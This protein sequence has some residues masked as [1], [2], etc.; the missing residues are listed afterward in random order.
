MFTF[1]SQ[2]L[3]AVKGVWEG[4]GCL[5]LGGPMHACMHTPGFSPG[6][7]GHPECSWRSLTPFHCNR[8]T[9]ALGSLGSLPRRARGSFHPI[10]NVGF[11]GGTQFP[12][13][14][15]PQTDISAEALQEDRD[16][17]MLLLYGLSTFWVF[18]HTPKRKRKLLP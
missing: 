17:P 10:R 15:N 8:C 1:P 6:F 12:S 18:P 13:W 11:A 5:S 14:C 16:P 7:A 9:P 4:R 3:V 2:R